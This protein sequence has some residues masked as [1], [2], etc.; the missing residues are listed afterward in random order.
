LLRGS[1]VGQAV[2]RSR[3]SGRSAMAEGHVVLGQ[4]RQALPSRFTKSSG[5]TNARTNGTPLGS[6]RHREKADAHHAKPPDLVAVR[7]VVRPLLNQVF[8]VWVLDPEAGTQLAPF[9]RRRLPRCRRL[10]RDIDA[11]RSRAAPWERD[12]YDSGAWRTGNSRSASSANRSEWEYANGART[13]TDQNSS[14][15]ATNSSLGASD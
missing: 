3:W 6:L 11:P 14:D 12:A 2:S 8:A 7:L 4:C 1:G 9:R 13:V 15:P 10:Y 5:R